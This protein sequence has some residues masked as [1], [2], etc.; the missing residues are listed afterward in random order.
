MESEVTYE[1]VGTLEKVSAQLDTHRGEL[2][3]QYH[4]ILKETLFENRSL[5]RAAMLS[6]AAASEV[7]S[8]VGYFRAPSLEM[9]MERGAQLCQKGF[10]EKTLLRLGALSRQFFL[11]HLE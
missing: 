1:E 6:D 4:Q 11:T 3:Q 8:L 2:L 7:E 10:S 5:I 9:A